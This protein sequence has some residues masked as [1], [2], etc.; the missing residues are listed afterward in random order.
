MKKKINKKIKGVKKFNPGGELTLQPFNQTG[1]Y[2]Q[3]V[4][5]QNMQLQAQQTQQLTS[6]VQNAAPKGGGMDAAGIAGK[7]GGMVNTAMDLAGNMIGT[8]TATSQSDARKQTVKNTLGGAAKGAAAGAA[9]GP[10]GAIVGGVVGLASGLVGKKGKVTSNGLYEAPTMTY[11]TG[12]RKRQN[13]KLEKKFE[14]MRAGVNS[15]KLGLQY[16]AQL[17]DDFNQD[18]DQDVQLMAH[19]GE[20]PSSMAYVDDGELI[21]TPQ[22]EML[23]VP[24]EGKPTDSNL[25][26]LP[27]G[28][29]ILSDSLKVPGTKQT[30]AQM[31]KKLMSKKKTKGKDI[32]AENSAK[33]NQ[34][35]DQMIHD[36]LFSLQEM[37]KKT[38]K[39]KNGIQTA[40]KGDVI[41]ATNK[42]KMVQIDDSRIYRPWNYWQDVYDSNRYTPGQ[43]SQSQQSVANR[44]I[45]KSNVGA[46]STSSTPTRK[47]TN[48]NFSFGPGSSLAAKTA[49]SDVAVNSGQWRGGIPYYLLS[50]NGDGQQ[51]VGSSASISKPSSK[52]KARSVQPAVASSGVS[53]VENMLDL[54]QEIQARP[55]ME[56]IPTS[57]SAGMVEPI[58]NYKPS[59]SGGNWQDTLSN[60]ATG[61]SSLAPALANL[62]AKPETFESVHNPYA[63][64]I[65]STM[66][67]RRFNTAPAE[68]AIRENRSIS[69]YNASKYNPT[70]G[71]NMAYRL[72]SAA[73]ANKAISDLYSQKS[74]IDNQYRADYASTLNNLGQQHV[75]ARN[76]AI[77]QN[78]RSRA[79]ARNANR[80]GLSQIGDFAQNQQLMRNQK[81][82]D[83][84]T[85]DAYAP[86]L[87][88]IYK[89]GDYANLMKQYRRG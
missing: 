49:A 33:L 41:T 22:G 24:E 36:K 76:L 75:S 45:S 85:L 3:M 57:R 20:I 27:V 38:N 59:G 84:A 64:Q 77:D 73:G 67:G 15:N 78:A 34:M 54:S 47:V 69:N 86:F 65:M 16:S 5:P 12:L 13:K 87:E 56:T 17:Q 42:D 21:N 7:A 62:G 74:N 66:S 51:P 23:E 1:T 4:Q 61:I 82:R 29:Q 89:S 72:Q 44:P 81:Q 80:A 70:T 14:D 46:T 32:Y 71:A 63:S 50:A 60:V 18:Y 2:Q 30:F 48:G 31:G 53:P 43:N 6:P 26:E 83:R 58:N 88:S 40:A 35:N 55:D 25:V 8:S 68:R 19:G 11:G 37:M 39:L 9:F 52:G 10:V 28:S 79:A